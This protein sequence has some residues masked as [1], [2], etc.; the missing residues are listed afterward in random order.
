MINHN[1]STHLKCPKSTNVNY[2][3]THIFQID[4]FGSPLLF[5][6]LIVLL[7]EQRLQRHSI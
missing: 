4:Q 3:H 6:R 7:E 2:L 5:E 1:Q